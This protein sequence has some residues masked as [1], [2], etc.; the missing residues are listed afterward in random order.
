MSLEKVLRINALVNS[1]QPH[2]SGGQFINVLAFR[3]DHWKYWWNKSEKGSQNTKLVDPHVQLHVEYFEC[4]Y[5]V[6]AYK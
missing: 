5:S 1:K 2:L 4:E 6:I 3:V